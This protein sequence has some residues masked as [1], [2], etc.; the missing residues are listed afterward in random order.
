MTGLAIFGWLKAGPDSEAR[1]AGD[2][3]TLARIEATL[4]LRSPSPSAEKARSQLKAE[5]Q[6]RSLTEAMTEARFG[7]KPVQGT[8]QAPAVWAQNPAHGLNCTF[9]TEGLR[10]TVRQDESP[11][12]R[13][14]NVGFW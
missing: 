13:L 7:V 4:E 3:L 12:A 6:S 1:A 14:H 5:G 10:F 9:S 2:T 8:G 11:S